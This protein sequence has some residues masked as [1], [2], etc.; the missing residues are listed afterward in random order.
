MSKNGSSKNFS[1][2]SP[3]EYMKYETNSKSTVLYSIC[4]TK[5]K[6]QV[7]SPPQKTMLTFRYLVGSKFLQRSSS[8][9]KILS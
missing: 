1:K 7:G 9:V 5:L 2:I 4:L 3:L 6:L 8:K